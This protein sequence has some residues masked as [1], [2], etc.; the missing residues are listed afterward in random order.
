[1][2]AVRG[3]EPHKGML[4]SFGGFLDGA[5]TFETAAA[6]ELAEEL[7]LTP[8]DYEP[9]KYLTS[10]AGQYPFRDEV[11]PVISVF[12]W[13]RLT[14][15]R[16]LTPR[17]DVAAIQTVPLGGLDLSLLHDQDIRV[18]IQALQRLFPD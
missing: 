18:G 3:I 15:T 14:T 10:G 4:D 17:D 16:V 13:T 11:L 2:L 12:F 7:A 5:E 6:R 9:L 8:H 1:M